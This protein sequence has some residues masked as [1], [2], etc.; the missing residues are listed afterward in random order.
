[1]SSFYPGQFCP[2][3]P[4]PQL[5][6]VKA[7]S[8]PDGRHLVAPQCTGR[9]TEV[10]RVRTTVQVCARNEW[11]WN[12]GQGPRDIIGFC[13]WLT[14][15]RWMDL[16]SWPRRR[17][18]AEESRPSHSP[19]WFELPLRAGLWAGSGNEMHVVRPSLSPCVGSEISD[20][21]DP[22]PWESWAGSQRPSGAQKPTGISL[23][24]QGQARWRVAPWHEGIHGP[25]A[26][27]LQKSCSSSPLLL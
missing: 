20:V 7:H 16:R 22:G 4:G 5:R 2:F 18:G 15:R 1:M 6:T 24:S 25:L 27:N 21:G 13:M 23:M 12:P 17:K 14:S 11:A 19:V 26:W 3:K 8:V 10:Q 9:E